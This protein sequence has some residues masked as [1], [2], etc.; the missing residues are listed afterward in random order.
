MS[1]EHLKTTL[2]VLISLVIPLP[3]TNSMTQ[4]A[5]CHSLN[6]T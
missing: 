6:A 3:S 4:Q 5:S 1:G 2:A